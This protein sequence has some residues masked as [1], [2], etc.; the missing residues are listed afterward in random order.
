MFIIIF[1]SINRVGVYINLCLVIEVIEFVEDIVFNI[2]F[3]YVFGKKWRYGCDEW[4]R[5]W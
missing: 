5:F 2:L 3:N 1:F 4:N